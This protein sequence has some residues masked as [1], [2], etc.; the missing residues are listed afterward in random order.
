MNILVTSDNHGLVK[1]LNLIRELHGD[2]D[3]FI[4]C[5]DSEMTLKQLS[6]WASVAGNNDYYAELPETRIVTVK[7]L[8]ILVTHSHLVSYFH[9]TDRLVQ[10]A[11]ENECQI[12]CFGHTH[13]FTHEM[14]DGIRLVNPGSLRYN[15][16]GTP[17]CYAIIHVDDQ[18]HSQVNVRRINFK[19]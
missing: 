13:I 4:H 11:K 14:V 12:V 2:Y 19:K 7:G 10:M 5:G 17:P 6:G 15:R 18:D 1:E 8:K 9:R 3:A 16:D